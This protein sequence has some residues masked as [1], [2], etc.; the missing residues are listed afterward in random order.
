MITEASK[1]RSKTVSGYQS[2]AAMWGHTSSGSFS[3]LLL[4]LL[5]CASVALFVSRSE[6][7]E[8]FVHLPVLFQFS[9]VTAGSLFAL[10]YAATVREFRSDWH[11]RWA[12]RVVG[13][14]GVA[15][16]VAFSFRMSVQVDRLQNQIAKRTVT[17]ASGIALC[18]SRTDDG[19]LLSHA[20]I[21]T[22]SGHVVSVSD[23]PMSTGIGRLGRAW[24]GVRYVD[25]RFQST[26]P[27]EV[28][29]LLV[30]PGG[31]SAAG[32]AERLSDF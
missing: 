19:D 30:L 13:A 2:D 20:S 15:F 32:S 22:R 23:R 7:Y 16:L 8:A 14:A 31:V 3:P 10:G 5:L 26:P 29:S 4:V 24:D 6:A 9:I 25:G 17:N 21:T 18:D 27:S 11:E 1:D 12:A 28:G